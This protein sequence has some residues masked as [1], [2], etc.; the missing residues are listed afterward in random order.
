MRI[1]DWSSDLSSSDLRPADAAQRRRSGGTYT[2]QYPLP[3]RPVGEMVRG[4][5][6]AAVP[7]RHSGICDLAADVRGGR[8]RCGDRPG[9]AVGCSALSSPGKTC[10]MRFK[11]ARPGRTIYRQSV[12]YGR[13]VLV[14]VTLGGLRN[15]KKKKNR[16]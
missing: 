13:G 8:L 12:V 11:D 3:R 4:V 14:R 7:G 1:S 6:G 10:A 5:E 9:H 2:A 15:I 16:S